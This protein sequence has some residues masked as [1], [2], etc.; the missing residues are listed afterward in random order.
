MGMPPIFFLKLFG[1]WLV[2]T[3]AI[4]SWLR[5]YNRQNYLAVNLDF[6]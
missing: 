3:V 2:V 6:R 1:I 4:L 5:F